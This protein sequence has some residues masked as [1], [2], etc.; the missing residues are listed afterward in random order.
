MLYQIYCTC[1]TTKKLFKNNKFK[2][3]AP[4]WNDKLELLDGFYSVLDI[5]DYFEDTVKKHDAVT[6]N[7]LIR[8]Y[9]NKIE[10]GI[11]IKVKTRYRLA[12]T[13][14]L[15]F[16]CF[17]YIDVFLL[18]FKKQARKRLKNF[19]HFLF[20]TLNKQVVK[21]CNFGTGVKLCVIKLFPHC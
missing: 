16:C 4:S 13:L 21:L 20:A 14:F 2:K 5:Q 3:S 17:F 1:K 12:S 6:D 7:L 19:A 15:F 11:S 9:G 18:F 10:N 8:I